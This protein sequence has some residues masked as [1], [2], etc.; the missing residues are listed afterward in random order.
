M[1]LIGYYRSIF[2][3]N[4]YVHELRKEDPSPCVI[5]GAVDTYRTFNTLLGQDNNPLC[6]N[7]VECLKRDQREALASTPRADVPS[8]S[9]R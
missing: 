1:N 2:E 8:A 9:K 4:P 5:C 6:L 3:D 7:Q